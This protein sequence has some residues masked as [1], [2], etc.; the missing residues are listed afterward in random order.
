[1]RVMK[2]RSSDRNT[3]EMVHAVKK[4]RETS[5]EESRDYLLLGNNQDVQGRNSTRIRDKSERYIKVEVEIGGKSERERASEGEVEGALE[6]RQER[7]RKTYKERRQT[8]A[9]GKRR[10]PPLAPMVRSSRTVL[11]LSARLRLVVSVL[12]A[13]GTVLVGVVVVVV[14]YVGGR[15][16]ANSGDERGAVGRADATRGEGTKGVDSASLPSNS[17]NSR[18][19][20]SANRIVGCAHRTPIL[21]VCRS[22]H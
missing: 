9:R 13:P 20:G 21:P 6:L 19:G 5:Q 7:E 8:R 4:R 14:Y 11:R 1:M 10:N 17:E 18:P 22:S 16:L 3:T 15:R 12:V 2:W